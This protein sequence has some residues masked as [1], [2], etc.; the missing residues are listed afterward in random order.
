M[1]DR[2]FSHFA[3]RHECLELAVRKLLNFLHGHDEIVHKHDCKNRE[4][5]IPDRKGYFFVYFR[6][7]VPGR[8]RENPPSSF[9]RPDAVKTASLPRD[10]PYL[11]RQSRIVQPET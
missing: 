2:D 11:I 1:S 8:M 10:T 9:T 7:H 6:Y 3:G 4:K 5:D